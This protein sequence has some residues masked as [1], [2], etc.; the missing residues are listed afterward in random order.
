[1]EEKDRDHH[2]RHHRRRDSPTPMKK[3]QVFYYISRNG[4]LEQPHFLEIP[5]FPNHPLRLKGTIKVDMCG[6]TCRKM[7]WFIPLKVMNTFSRHL[8]LLIFMPPVQVHI[9]NNN[10][11]QPV[12]EP[13]L[14]TKTRKQQLAP[15]PLPHHPHSDLEY[16]E[17]E[18]YEYDDGD[19]NAGEPPGQLRLRPSRLDVPLRN[20]LP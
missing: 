14:P 17:D 12:Q 15:T 11:R 2:H 18:D 6:T 3:A 1:M 13:N 10:P 5:L 20:G 8:N 19:K 4:R 9:P 16:D 7:T